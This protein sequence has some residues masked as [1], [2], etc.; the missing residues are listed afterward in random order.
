MK[1][2][3]TPVRLGRP[4]S[5]AYASAR[6]TDPDGNPLESAPTTVPSNAP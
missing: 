1:P 2:T 5:A 6:V 3:T 4:V